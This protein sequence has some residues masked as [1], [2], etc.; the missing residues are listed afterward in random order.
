M[1]RDF[2][3]KYVLSRSEA[4]RREMRKQLLGTI[5]ALLAIVLV[6]GA[7]TPGTEAATHAA[8]E[9]VSVLRTD[10]GVSIEMTAKGALTPKVETLSSPAR[11]VVDLPNTVVATSVSRIHV[12]NSGVSGVRIGTD[13]G[14]TTRVVVD[15]DRLCKYELVPGPGDK[16]TLKLQSS[17]MAAKNTSVPAKAATTATLLT[18]AG[19]KPEPSKTAA[20]DFVVVTPAYAPKKDIASIEPPVRAVDAATKFVERPEGDLMPAANAAIQGADQSSSTPSAPAAS[21]AI[22][23]AVNLAAEQ[24][25]HPQATNGPKYTGEPISVNLKDVDLKD[26][27]RLIHEISGLNVVL[28][29]DVKGTLTI[30]LDDVPWDQALDIVLK[31]NTLTRQLDGNVLRIATVDTVRKEAEARRA[32]QEAEALAVEKVQVTRFLSYAHS[33]DVATTMKKV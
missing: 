26:F 8:L 7:Q 21:P 13:A 31:N 23:P 33:K 32:A 2:F 17:P 24:K 11:I 30:V 4:G 25:T 1:D 28:D 18:P 27:F 14:A 12:G 6:A 15:L 19:L 10:N 29:P 16:L 5:L 20:T 22:Q 3:N 9:K